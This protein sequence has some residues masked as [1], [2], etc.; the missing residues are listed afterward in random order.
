MY[1]PHDS[2]AYN[3]SRRLGKT[4]IAA[5]INGLESS[6]IR[7]VTQD[8]R[9]EQSQPSILP[10]CGVLALQVAVL[11]LAGVDAEASVARGERD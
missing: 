3:L 9:L 10:K 2:I 8:I 1:Y 7:E 4:K 6:A 11:R 5:E